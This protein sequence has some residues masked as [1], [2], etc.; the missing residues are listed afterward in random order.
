M[1]HR[2]A[3]LAVGIMSVNEN[4]AG[5]GPRCLASIDQCRR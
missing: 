2:G 1:S 3:S 5:E 4:V